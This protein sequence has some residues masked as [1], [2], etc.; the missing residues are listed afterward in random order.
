[1]MQHRSARGFTLAEA[2]IAVAILGM[3]GLLTAGTFSR[4][5]DARERALAITSH[6]HE[7]R[8]AMQRMSR[9][10]SMAFLSEHKNC[11][12]PR[13]DTLFVGRRA[14]GG[15]RLD[16]TSFSHTKTQKD[17][18]ESDQNELSYFVE[19]DP[20]DPKKQVLM[21]REQARIDDEPDK[22][23]KQ[24]VLAEN[25]T[26]LRFE[27]YD[28][29]DDR[30]RDDWDTESSDYKGRM[31]MF[32][33]IELKAKGLKG[34]EETFVTKTRVFLQKPMLIVGGGFAPCLD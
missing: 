16:F 6:Y 34:E 5:M 28:S 1:M 14:L 21:R 20:D 31:P 2:L 22:G 4:A 10:I 7:I 11:E 30:W 3:I 8:Q 13:T 33:S 18:N 27:F 24:Q 19:R 23:G 9:E 29:K 15:M 17:A 26:E 25:V 32:V 12:D